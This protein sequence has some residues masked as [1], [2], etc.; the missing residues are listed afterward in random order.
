MCRHPLYTP[1]ISQFLESENLVYG[2]E[3]GTKSAL[4]S[5]YPSAL[6]QLFHGIFC[7]GT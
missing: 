6:V 7:E 3:A 1:K 5:G 4:G 2:A